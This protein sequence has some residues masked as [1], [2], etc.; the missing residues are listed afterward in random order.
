MKMTTS[1]KLLLVSQFQM[2]HQ[3]NLKY[4]MKNI[5]EESGLFCGNGTIYKILQDSALTLKMTIMISVL[6]VMS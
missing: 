4:K 5:R 2:I 1:P 6:K 3:Q